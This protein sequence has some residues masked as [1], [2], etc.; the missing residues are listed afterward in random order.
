MKIA[1]VIPCYNSQDTIKSTLE[2]VANFPV[3][4]ID[5]NSDDKTVE[6][7]SRSHRNLSVSRHTKHVS[8]TENWARAIE[9]FLKS[10]Y[11]WMKWLFTGDILGP[12]AASIL[13]EA[14]TAY[15]ESKLIVCNMVE[16]DGKQRRNWHP[17]GLTGTKLFYPKDAL[18]HAAQ[19][20]NWFGPPLVQCIHRDALKEL[21]SFGYLP[22]VADMEMALTIAKRFPVL[23]FAKTIGEFHFAHRKYFHK[24]RKS[25]KAIFEESL[26]Q[27]KAIESYEELSN[28]NEMSRKFASKVQFQAFKRLLLRR[29]LSI[30]E[31]LKGKFLRMFKSWIK[32]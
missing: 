32:K 11:E 6:I 15:P 2:S 24:Y 20:G 26:M 23:Y 21:P 25:P 31:H 8:R 4:L 5:N 19:Y 18:G 28:E 13:Q 29:D 3:I 1:V 30:T 12:E 10:D 22:W 9:I 16:V 7:A 14:T 17:A 27:L